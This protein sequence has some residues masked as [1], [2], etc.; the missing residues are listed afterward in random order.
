MIR[1]VYIA[2]PYSRCFCEESGELKPFVVGPFSFVAG[3]SKEKYTYFPVLN[4]TVPARFVRVVLTSTTY[5]F[6]SHIAIAE[7]S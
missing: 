7:R 2:C 6:Y 3:Y 4:L 1:M 5:H